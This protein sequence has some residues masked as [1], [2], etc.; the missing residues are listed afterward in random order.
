M[1]ECLFFFVN[2]SDYCLWL[3]FLNFI[4]HNFYYCCCF[5]CSKSDQF[6]ITVKDQGILKPLYNIN[7]WLV[8]MPFS[9]LH[10]RPKQPYGPPRSAL[11]PPCGP[12]GSH[13]HGNMQSGPCCSAASQPEKDPTAQKEAH[14]NRNDQDVLKTTQ[15]KEE[16]Q[17]W[18]AGGWRRFAHAITIILIYVMN[19]SRINIKWLMSPT[20]KSNLNQPQP[21]TQCRRLFPPQC[22]GNSTGIS[23]RQI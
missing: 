21:Q 6:S 9:R 23:Q 4:L 13:A 17:P 22:G 12:A 3:L 8:S 14:V 15:Q 11:P 19:C 10:T 1:S 20:F 2:I 7:V 5:Q 18:T 16:R